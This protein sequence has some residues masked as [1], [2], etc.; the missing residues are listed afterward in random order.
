MLAQRR[1]V[2]VLKFPRECEHRRA[3]NNNR[4]G[5]APRPAARRA[6][7]QFQIA[8]SFARALLCLLLVQSRVNAITRSLHRVAAPLLRA[9]RAKLVQGQDHRS[10]NYAASCRR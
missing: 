4:C 1:V 7:F 9:R 2:G 5:R 8:L 6:A 3:G 10:A